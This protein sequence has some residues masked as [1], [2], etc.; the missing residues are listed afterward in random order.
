MPLRRQTTSIAS[1]SRFNIA[2]CFLKNKKRNKNR[3]KLHA[4]VLQFHVQHFHVLLFMPCVLCP[5]NS[6]SAISYPAIFVVLHFHV[7]PLVSLLFFPPSGAQFIMRLEI[8]LR[9]DRVDF[10]GGLR[11]QDLTLSACC[12]RLAQMI[13]L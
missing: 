7:N 9:R 2:S 4:F 8:C 6:C 1:W 3:K 11:G 5:A 12:L 13:K 10:R